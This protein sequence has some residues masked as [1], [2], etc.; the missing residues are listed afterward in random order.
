MKKLTISL[1]FKSKRV[2]TSCVDF[3][4]VGHQCANPSR[5]G[6]LDRRGSEELLLEPLQAML[7]DAAV[8]AC[9][10]MEWTLIVT[11]VAKYG[12]MQRIRSKERVPRLEGNGKIMYGTP[13][14]EKIIEFFS[15]NNSDNEESRVI[16]ERWRTEVY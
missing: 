15:G 9:D 2:S 7:Y 6:G 1:Y 8:R 12:L 16:Q 5:T 3:D 14:S 11:D 4:S 13:T 10:R